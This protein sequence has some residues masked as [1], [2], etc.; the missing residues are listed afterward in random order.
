[1]YIHY[2]SVE[3]HEVIYVRSLAL[4]RPYFQPSDAFK[5]VPTHS[6]TRLKRIYPAIKCGKLYDRLYIGSWAIESEEIGV[7]VGVQQVEE[8]YKI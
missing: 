8:R 5:E 7:G 1:M 6:I 4:S 3:V 2:I